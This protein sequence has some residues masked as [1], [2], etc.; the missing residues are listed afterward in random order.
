MTRDPLACD[1]PLAE[2]RFVYAKAAADKGDFVTAAEVLEQA[3][4]RAPD[5][6][7]AWFA[8][9]EAREKLGDLDGAADAFRAALRCDPADA[10]AAM[11]RL[12][13]IGRGDTPLALPHAYVT[14][15]FDQ[16]APRFNAH[17]TDTL[18][19]RA[20]ALI[21]AA[22]GSVAPARRFSCALDLGCGAGLMGEALRD[23]VERFI[24]VDLSP[25]M[26]EQAR[27]RG[28]YDA[29]AVDDATAFL[30]RQAQPAFDLVVAAD[31]LVYI[32]DLAPL[33]AA[34]AAA[35][36]ADGLFAFSL[37]RFEG[38]RFALGAT[39]RFAHSRAY[40]EATAGEAGL[41]PFIIRSACARREG[42]AD[43]PGLI[44]VFERKVRRA[45]A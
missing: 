30:R 13:L 28:A 25:A 45:G 21:A 33:L 34:V 23:D 9:G 15:L 35:L 11:A 7:V 6:A 26:I 43:V 18:G 3:L 2:R 19:Y 32:G 27:E 40:V 16:Y 12:A 4:E 37:E 38:E 42:G 5:W 29:L 1:D 44:C 20:P 22:L 10:Q 24:G 14:R 17:L 8:L 36:T 41:R 39:M 31:S